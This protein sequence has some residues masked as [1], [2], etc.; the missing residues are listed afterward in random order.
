VKNRTTNSKPRLHE[1]NFLA[2]QVRPTQDLSRAIAKWARVWNLPGL[3]R[4][5]TAA[6][7]TRMRRS[8]GSAHRQSGSVRINSRLAVGHPGLLLETLCHEVAHIAAFR[9]HG[10][11]AK[12]H[13]PEWRALV[14]AAGYKPT[15]MMFC[16]RI[17]RANECPAARKALFKYLCVTCQSPYIGRRKDSRLRCGRCLDMGLSGILRLVDDQVEQCQK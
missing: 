16:R 6:F 5:V 1:S 17:E 3:A 2:P 13:G 14:L 7:S 15:T 11:K 12:P 4:S 8:L 10:K 9:L